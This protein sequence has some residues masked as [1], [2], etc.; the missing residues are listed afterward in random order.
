MTVRRRYF[1]CGSLSY[2]CLLCFLARLFFDG[3]WSPAGKGLTSW[4]SFVMSNSEFVT[5]P[6]PW[7]GVVLDLSIPDLCPLP[8]FYVHV[9]VFQTFLRR[10]EP[11]DDRPYIYGISTSNQ[12]LRAGGG[13]YERNTCNF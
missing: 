3:L 13:V 8:Y 5:F 4:L 10:I 2:K 1:F 7:S 12:V 6:Y 9:A 11:D